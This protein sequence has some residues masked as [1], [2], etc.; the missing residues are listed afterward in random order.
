[1]ER[2]AATLPRSLR[3]LAAL[4]VKAVPAEGWDGIFGVAA[5]LIPHRL[6]YGQAGDKLHKLA[7]IIDAESRETMYQRLI[8]QW[9]DPGEIVRD[10]REPTILLNDVSQW[11]R[12]AGFTEQMMLLDVLGYL[13][14]DILVKLDRASM[15]VGLEGRVPLL[16]HRI[17]EF[18]W[19]LPTSM[20][21]RDGRGKWLLRQVLAR[22]L[23]DALIERPKMG[24]G[25]PIDRW[26]R[27][28]LREW[29]EELLVEKWLAEAGYFN[30][31]VVR[32]TWEEHISGRYN[33]QYQL[34]PVLIF[35]AWRDYH[36]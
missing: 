19:R 15:A 14:D 28:D 17:M 7:A 4:A 18:S 11:P 22:Y 27:G 6:R 13:P 8:S 35:E 2:A 9:H 26:L 16:D 3:R 30:V 36:L 31:K 5:P 33:R 1:M 29:A 10:V 32:R 12:S 23:P 24:F 34:W 20:K 21:I 25:V